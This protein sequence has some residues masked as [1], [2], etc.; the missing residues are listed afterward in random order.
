MVCAGAGFYMEHMETVTT[1]TSDYV[2]DQFP[3]YGDRGLCKATVSPLPAGV[4]PGVRSEGFS[5]FSSV[6]SRS[7]LRDALHCPLPC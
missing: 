4:I 2:N 5:V 3:C 1:L 6:V 7:V